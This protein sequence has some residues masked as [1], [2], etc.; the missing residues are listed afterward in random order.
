M[1]Q[2]HE[3]VE[4]DAKRS[5]PKMM[6]GTRRNRVMRAIWRRV[7][8]SKMA[9]ADQNALASDVEQVVREIIRD[10]NHDI[11]GHGHPAI[12]TSVKHHGEEVRQGPDRGE[13]PD[14]V[15][16]RAVGLPR[17]SQP[18]RHR[19]LVDAETYMGAEPAAV[20][21]KDQP[22]IFDGRETPEQKEK[23]EE[24]DKDAAEQDSASRQFKPTEDAGTTRRRSAPQLARL[25]A[26]PSDQGGR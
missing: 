3:F 24:I 13:A 12:T 22:S 16:R 2:Q 18:L 26:A 21:R 9:E 8:Q 14:A 20:I 23:R 4:A 1:D 6:L 25:D 10:V 7:D 19:R 17:P 15:H 5:D 11:A